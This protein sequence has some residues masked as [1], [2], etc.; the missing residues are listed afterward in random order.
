MLSDISLD[1]MYEN[2]AQIVRTLLT[3]HS[4]EDESIE[5]RQKHKF[6][7]CLDIEF[8]ISANY[9]RYNPCLLLL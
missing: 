7:K 9:L 6:C 3:K 8:L 5:N 4:H 2:Q 1:K